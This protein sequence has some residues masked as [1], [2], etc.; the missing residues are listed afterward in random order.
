MS[1]HP[2]RPGPRK[3]LIVGLP[4][5]QGRNTSEAYSLP[6]RKKNLDP[7]SDPQDVASR[8]RHPGGVN[9]LF[10]DGSVHFM[11]NSINIRTWIQLGSINGGEVVSSDSY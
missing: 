8:S 7:R 9:T 6:P 2:G 1:N 5:G 3:Q 4:Q 10:G 11:K